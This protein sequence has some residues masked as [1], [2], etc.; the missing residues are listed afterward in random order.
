MKHTVIQ[1]S[2][3]RLQSGCTDVN[4]YWDSANRSV[5]Q[6]RVDHIQSVFC[7]ALVVS[8]SWTRW[9]PLLTSVSAGLEFI[10]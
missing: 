4:V 5:E 9:G 10:N 8:Y 3:V 1:C 6:C 2:E 7:A